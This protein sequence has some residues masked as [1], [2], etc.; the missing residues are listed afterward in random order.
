MQ[1][2]E[3]KS[4]TKPAVSV[5]MVISNVER[6]V[7]EAIE[8]ILGQTFRDFEFI[9]VDFGST[10]KSKAIAS[11]Y[12]EQDSRIKLHAISPCFLPKARNAGCALAQG[13]YIAVMDADDVSVPERLIW[14][15]EFMEKHPEVSV[16][17]GAVDWIDTNGRSLGTWGNPV[18]D[19][20]IRSALLER[21][22]LWQPTVL[23][24][25]EA[26]IR[27]G[28]YRPF[29]AEDYDMWLR[30]SEHFQLAN[31]KQV[32]LKYRVHPYQNSVRKRTRQTVGYLAARLSA[33]ARKRGDADPLDSV[34]EV[35]P[36]L[37]SSL[38]V[39]QEQQQT[40]FAGAYLQW[41]RNLYL[42]GESSAALSA[43]LEMLRSSQWE[44]ADLAVTDIRILTARIYWQQRQLINSAIAV[45]HAIRKQPL[46]LA[47]PLRHLLRWVGLTA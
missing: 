29:P 41:I 26:F 19:Q 40:A 45:G 36:E 25:R 37:L 46:V 14:Q 42:A 33:A 20:E 6:F 47:R 24:R 2:Y 39:T 1:P 16:L 13:R 38:G 9:I 30:M 7:A 23:M 28:G 35:T 27:V 43:A 32:V 44:H 10:D 15:V 34:E 5:V 17:G 12:A 4:M 18:D 22:P 11:M 31:L 8:S 21:C 3:T